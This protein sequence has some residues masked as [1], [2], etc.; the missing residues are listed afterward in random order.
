MIDFREFTAHAVVGL[1]PEQ[2]RRVAKALDLAIA[3][4]AIGH[5][6]NNPSLQD[7]KAVTARAE[8][9]IGELRLQAR[10]V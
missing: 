6:T 7:I 1:P 9:L 5:A 8:R 4:G 3:F 10:A 2:A